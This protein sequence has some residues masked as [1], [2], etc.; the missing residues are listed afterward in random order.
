MSSGDAIV[1]GRVEDVRPYFNKSSVFVCPLRS[2]SGMQTKILE[3][4]A[5]EVPVV[6]T[7]LGFE[8]LEAIRGEHIIVADGAKKFAQEIR[9]Q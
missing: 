2:G 4:M 7:S 6:T 8:A 3:A 9:Q 1:T 5:M